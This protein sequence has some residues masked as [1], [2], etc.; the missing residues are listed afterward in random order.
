M[1]FFLGG[2]VNRWG[3]EGGEGQ[4]LVF[5]TLGHLTSGTYDGQNSHPFQ[6]SLTLPFSVLSLCCPL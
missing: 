3:R 5:I 6:E 1:G 4:R 2:I